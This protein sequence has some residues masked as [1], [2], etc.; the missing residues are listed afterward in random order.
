MDVPPVSIF[1]CVTPSYAHWFEAPH[2]INT[3]TSARCQTYGNCTLGICRFD[4]GKKV[5]EMFSTALEECDTEYFCIVGA[6]DWIAPEYIENC[7]KLLETDKGKVAAASTY[8]FLV[9]RDDRKIGHYEG[10]VAGVWRTEIARGLGGF[11]KP[12]SHAGDWGSAAELWA[13]ARQHAGFKCLQS[14][15][16]DYYYRIWSGSVSKPDPGIDAKIARLKHG[17]QVTL[18][19]DYR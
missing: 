8:A 5:W 16:Y 3:I 4:D 6:D 12:S 1:T 2:L 15:T 9:D 14:P 11:R 10:W 17:E 7:V 13:R 19:G 18:G